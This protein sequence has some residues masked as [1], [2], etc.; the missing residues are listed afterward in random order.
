MRYLLVR[1]KVADF[2]RWKRVFDS[3][4]AAQREAGLT[5]KHVLRNM[6]D[7][8]EVFLLLGMEDVEKARRFVTSPKV[9]DAQAA[10]TVVDE[11]DIF[12]LQE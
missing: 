2:T 12:Y 11:P 3:H 5:V 9:P 1:H 7:L 6:D 10:S 8:G 4:A